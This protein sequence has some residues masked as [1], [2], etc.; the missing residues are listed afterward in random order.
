MENEKSKNGIIGVLIGI[1]ICLIVV[2]V[3]ILTGVIKL[4]DS[5]KNSGNNSGDKTTTTVKSIKL[6]NSKDYVYD[7]DY[8]YD[9]QQ[10]TEYA[11]RLGGRMKPGNDELN[12]TEGVS[13][14]QS[15]VSDFKVPY[16][17]IDSEDAK[18]ANEEIK[19]IYI[20]YAK[21]FDEPPLWVKSSDDPTSVGADYYLRYKAFINNDVL[22]IVIGSCTILSGSSGLG[23]TYNTY[24]FDLKTGKLLYYSDL[25]S[26]LGYSVD[27]SY[28]KITNVLNSRTDLDGVK[29]II[30]N[31]HELDY[32]TQQLRGIKLKISDNNSFYLN[33]S[34]NL[35]FFIVDVHGVAT[36]YGTM[37]HYIEIK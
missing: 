16:I 36:K 33:E 11:K 23:F 30:S 4:K 29:E 3:L 12:L 15:L 22:S 21:S 31:Q 20:E 25:V 34:G 18:K 9:G 2:I 10:Y 1:I 8:K 14:E 7:A 37:Q 6:D 17:N 13:E 5:E 27:E 35:C 26:K 19:N 28:D 32:I 24:N